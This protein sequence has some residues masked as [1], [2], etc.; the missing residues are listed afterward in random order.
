MLIG[1]V[2]DLCTAFGP[3]MVQLLDFPP[4][5]EMLAQGRRSRVTRT[6]TLATWASKELRKLKVNPQVTAPAASW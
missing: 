4:I 2:G 6:K 5:Y 3:P 1:I